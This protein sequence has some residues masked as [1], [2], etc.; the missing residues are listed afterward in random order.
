MKILKTL[1]SVLSLI[2]LFAA[3]S[4]GQATMG[5][6]TLSAAVAIGDSTIYLT[7]V[8]GV[9]A[10]GANNQ[11]NTM[12][13]VD[14]EAM[15]VLSI[16]GTAV[17]VQRG[18][19]GTRQRAHNSGAT[20]Y[21][22]PPNYYGNQDPSGAC[23]STNLPVLPWVVASTGNVWTCTAST[24]TVV[25]FPALFTLTDGYAYIPP[26]HCWMTPATTT[27]ATGPALV[28][29]AAS[30][31]V[32]SG[33]TDTTGGTV[34]VTCSIDPPN[35]RTTSGKGIVINDVSFL[36]GIQTTAVS[37]IGTASVKSVTYPAIAGA[38]AGTVS[39]ALGGSLTVLP[40]SLQ[41]TTTTAGQCFNENVAM[42]TPIAAAT[43]NRRLVFEQAF[44]TAG[45]SATVLQ[46]CGAIV[47][48]TNVPI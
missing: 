29:A 41:L 15:N 36:Y 1:A 4:F 20:I 9:S 8:T 11:V 22:G 12:L 21:L 32:L 5:S 31:L 24:W 23:T 37:A 47:H 7:S 3:L 18:I 33:T 40:A 48:Y 13:F 44:T 39:T 46:V 26:D 25:N 42:G 6:T 19:E 34:T 28:R 35:M 16:S 10:M 27:F 2:A 43:D 14:R 30:N 45:S 17:T 38:A